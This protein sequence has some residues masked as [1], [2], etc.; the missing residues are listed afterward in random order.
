MIDFNRLTD[1]TKE[2]LYAYGNRNDNAEYLT[3]HVNNHQILKEIECIIAVGESANV[4]IFI[5]N[6]NALNTFDFLVSDWVYNEALE[7]YTLNTN[8]PGVGVN[9]FKKSD[10]GMV[11][12]EFV[13]IVINSEN[14]I[15]LQAL[16]PFN[17]YLIFA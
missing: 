1:Y 16:S 7:V 8:Q 10:A 2:I 12:T 15:T 4:R 14:N 13:D 11:T 5:N 9:I 17:G 3:P 6:L